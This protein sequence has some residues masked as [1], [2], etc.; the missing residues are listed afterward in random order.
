MITSRFPK[1]AIAVA[2]AMGTV[3]VFALDQATTNAAPTQIVIAGASA[4]RDAFLVLASTELCQAGTVDVFRATPTGGQDFRVYSCTLVPT[5]VVTNSVGALLGS[6]AGTN[7]KITYRSEGGSAWGPVSIVAKALDGSFPGIQQLDTTGTCGAAANVAFTI[8]PTQILTLPT[9]DCPVTNYD[10]TSDTF[11][12]GALAPQQT[13][14]GISDVEPKMFTGTNHPSSNRF[15][16][17]APATYLPALK[18]LPAVRGFGETFGV[19]VSNTGANTSGLTNLTRAQVA[20]I[21][22]TGLGGYTNWNKIPGLPGGTIQ[23]KRREPGSGTQVEAGAYFLNVNCGDSYTFVTD[24]G[25]TV[26]EYGAG[27]ALTAAVAATADS[28][29]FANYANPAPSGTHFVTINGV[30]GDRQNAAD[31]TYEYASELTTTQASGLSGNTLTFAGAIQ[32]IIARA[33]T[34]PDAPYVF[35]IPGLA[36]NTAGTTVSGRPVARQTKGGNTCTPFKGS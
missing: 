22:T 18:A 33:A 20:A 6:V 36:G 31:G 23:K 2:M 17:P 32:A 8:S 13:Q 14:L 25:G 7:A 34:I 24:N 10:L 3:P 26:I 1:V 4:A 19:L 16:Q 11:I 9:H 28:V 21:F 5:S 15:P 35:A 12:S 27:G 29:G 30:S